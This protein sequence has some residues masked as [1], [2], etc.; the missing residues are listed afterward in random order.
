MA[1]VQPTIDAIT[2]FSFTEFYAKQNDFVW[3]KDALPLAKDHW[4]VTAPLMYLAGVG[5]LKSITPEGGIPLG[6]LP[7][8]HN[9]V[10]VLWCVLQ[11]L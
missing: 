2:N 7:I 9:V 5:I 6:P 8:L 1:F 10:L 4:L 11:P 3:D